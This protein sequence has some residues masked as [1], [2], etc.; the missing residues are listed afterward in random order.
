MAR[1]VNLCWLR[2]SLCNKRLLVW[3]DFNPYNVTLNCQ[4]QEIRLNCI[5]ENPNKMQIS[6]ENKSQIQIQIHWLK[7]SCRN[8]N[9]LNEYLWAG[10]SGIQKKKRFPLSSLLSFESLV[11]VKENNDRKRKKR[12]RKKNKI[13]IEHKPNWTLI[14]LAIM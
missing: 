5:N 8:L 11:F 3:Y 7:A 2:R 10:G 13:Q 9:E 6:K 4:S 12:E 1:G 14:T